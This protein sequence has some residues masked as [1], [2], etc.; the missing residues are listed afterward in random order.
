MLTISPTKKDVISNYSTSSYLNAVVV[1]YVHRDVSFNEIDSAIIIVVHQDANAGDIV[2]YIMANNIVV[3]SGLDLEARSGRTGSV[4]SCV[5]AEAELNKGVVCSACI[6]TATKVHTF[7]G[8]SCE[9]LVRSCRLG[10]NWESYRY[11]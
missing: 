4:S 7:S 6:V 9:G 11:R 5:V 3:R 1:G 8:A 10:K 2:A